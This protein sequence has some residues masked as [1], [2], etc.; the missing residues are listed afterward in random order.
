[1]EAAE[2]G[3]KDFEEDQQENRKQGLERTAISVIKKSR[4]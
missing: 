1:M 3:A 4:Q 2:K